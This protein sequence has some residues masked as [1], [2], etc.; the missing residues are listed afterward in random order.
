VESVHEF[1]FIT[2]CLHGDQIVSLV[3]YG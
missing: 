3:T 1:V 2:F